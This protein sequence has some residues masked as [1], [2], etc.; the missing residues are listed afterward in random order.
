[1]ERRNN[2]STEEN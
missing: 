2:M 1:M